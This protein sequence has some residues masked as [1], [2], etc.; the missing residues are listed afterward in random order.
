M[1][2]E[3]P[4]FEVFIQRAVDHP[5]LPSD[6]AL[7]AYAKTT[8]GWPTVRQNPGHELTLRF[9]DAE[10]S[11]QLNKQFRGFD[12]P[13]NVLSFPFHDG[14]NPAGPVLPGDE[15][16]GDLAIC[17]PIIEQEAKQQG[18]TM[19]DHCAHLVIHGTLHCLGYTHDT[20]EHAEAMEALEVAILAEF[21][22]ANP[23]WR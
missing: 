8:L 13:T 21:N 1:T 15:N 19:H 3:S 2:K 10:E 17:V 18:K 14:E 12:K 7:A 20:D 9:V 4:D 16:I 6:Q 11:N 5:D 22:I 23:Y